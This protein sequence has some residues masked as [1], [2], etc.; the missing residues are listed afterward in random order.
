MRFYRLPWVEPLEDR[1]LAATHLAFTP[2]PS[3]TTA[4]QS[5]GTTGVQ[6]FVEDSLNH[7]VTTD[8]STVTIALGPGSSGGTLS[9]TFTASVVSGVAIFSTLSID[10]VGAGYT[11]AA[12]DGAPRP[13]P[14][15]F[16]VTAAAASQVVFSASRPTRRRR[17]P[18]VP[19]VTVL[20][21][22]QF[23]NV[24]TCDTSSVTMALG[25]NPGGRWA[26]L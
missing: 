12:V 8:A 10:P 20:V 6:V 25:S 15:P 14:P 18:S 9:G 5:I 13:T 21:E 16:A 7:V 11:L 1:I 19:P 23:G 2:Q 4:G 17:Q 3:D 24:V 26:A 22:D